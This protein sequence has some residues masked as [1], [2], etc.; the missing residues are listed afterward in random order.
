[1]NGAATV[2]MAGA[3]GTARVSMRALG[4]IRR[5]RKIQ[6]IQRIGPRPVAIVEHANVR[7]DPGDAGKEISV[8]DGLEDV[9]GVPDLALGRRADPRLVVNDAQLLAVEPD[10][11]D[12]G[13]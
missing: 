7:D 4:T 10:G 6:R 1:M 3:A 9:H 11:V 13:L 8:E 2:G 12:P 5:I